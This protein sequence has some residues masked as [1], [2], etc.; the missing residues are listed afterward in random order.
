MQSSTIRDLFLDYFRSKEHLIM[1]SFPL[2]PQNDP[3]LLLIGAG[4]APLK[5]YFTGEKKPPH[6]RVVTCQKCVRTPDIERVGYTG[7][8]ATFFEMLGNFSFGD[9]FK[10]EAIAWA[11]DLILNGYRLPVERLWVSIYQDDDEAFKIWNENIGVPADRI[12]RMGKEDNFWEIG[13]GPCG[14]CSEIYYDLGEAAGCGSPDCAV[15]CDCDR[16]LEI[17]NLVFTQFSREASGE[18]VELKQKNIDT[19]A[20]LERV[21][22]ALQ[23][24]HSLY[25][26]DQV[27]PLYDHFT[28]L[29]DPARRDQQVPLRVVTE[30]S[31]GTTF[32]IADGV[33]PSNEG[34][35]YV[36]RRLLRRAVR[37]GRLL[38]IEGDFM[39][40]AATLVI[41]QMGSA[42]PN[43]KERHDYIRQVVSLE[44]QKFQETLA[45]GTDILEGYLEKMEKEG[46]KVLPGNIAFK[47]YDTFGFP[48]DLTAEILQEKGFSVDREAFGANLK[49]QQERAR[50]AARTATGKDLNEHY[51]AAEALETVFTGHESL[52]QDAELILTLVGGQAV[53]EIN[54]GEEAELFLDQS[55][56][57]AEA[58]GQ[59]GDT[60]L[61]ETEDAVFKVIN[62]VF[63]PS[64]QIVHQGQVTEGQFKTGN[65]VQARV[66]WI[67]RRGICRSHTSTH[68]LHRALRRNL[69][70][71][72]NQAGSLVAPDRLRFD[73]NHF[74]ALTSEQ[75]RAVEEEV[76]LM[77][78]DNVQVTAKLT[79]LE[80]AKEA[81]ATALFTD[82]YEEGSVRMVSAGDYTRELCGGTHVAATGEIGLF[83][84]VAEEGIGSGLRRIEAVVGLGAYRQAIKNDQ[85][86]KTIAIA[87]NSDL[88]RLEDKVTEYLA[89]HKM[90]QKL[91]QE[92]KQ[93]N[94]AVEVKSLL[95]NAKEVDGAKLLSAAV[96]ADSLESLR[97]V[98]DEVKS[99]LS[100]VAVVLG[101][102]SNG[103]VILVSSV[104]ADLIER[105]I[106]ADG[107][108]KEV[109][110]KVGGGGGGKADLAQAGGSDPAALPAALAAVEELVRNQ[111]QTKS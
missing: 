69:G 59:V 63:T 62:T 24:V 109:A 101:A 45:Q 94:A 43:L 36:L 9:Y 76:N 46:E 31:R 18:L 84:I 41:D 48:L 52:E 2:I 96:T 32:L 22:M 104:T 33:I 23:G 82:K 86:L 19:G 44:E 95:A 91:N 53:S 71:H 12:K 111:L 30:H 103:K 56:F 11:W 108:I 34:R 40:E 97:L 13:L 89:E 99:S 88:L 37:F 67:R 70:D 85:L 77:A 74:T 83:K 100:S 16:Y 105:G 110:R 10:E 68:L 54:K 28:S 79:T 42:Y 75:L 93:K 38:G 90:L 107:L 25:D 106:R 64:G 21:A 6:P 7:R 73:F 78:L 47:L 58:G 17:W 80:T 55:P 65:R 50:A 51:K 20:G 81:G 61:I 72:I 8:H 15:G 29:A 57:Y 3:T 14:P 5:T 92:L 39:T 27:R 4:M 66:D 49:E 87:M 102:V 26:T 35:G 1:P 98:M 60:G